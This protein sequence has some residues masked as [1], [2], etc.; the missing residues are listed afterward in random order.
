LAQPAVHQAQSARAAVRKLQLQSAAPR[1]MSAK[2]YCN[3]QYRQGWRSPKFYLLAMRPTKWSVVL[4]LAA[5]LPT[6][7]NAKAKAATHA[8]KT[9]GPSALVELS[10]EAK[11]KKAYKAQAP[12]WNLALSGQTLDI[13]VVPDAPFVFYDPEEHEE[14]QYSGLIIGQRISWIDLPLINPIHDSQY[15][16][17]NTRLAIQKQTTQTLRSHSVPCVSLLSQI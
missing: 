12:S 2:Q 8:T 13:V 1:R 3:S 9:V 6:R 5:C 14:S 17:H 10:A 16:T 4:L 7:G 15:T 11:R